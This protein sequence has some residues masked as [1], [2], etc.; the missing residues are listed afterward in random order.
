M[1]LMTLARIAIRLDG[2]EESTAKTSL[3][4]RWSYLTTYRRRLRCTPGE[5]F[6]LQL[7]DISR[8]YVRAELLRR[9]CSA[10]DHSCSKRTV[11]SLNATE[12]S[13]YQQISL[14]MLSGSEESYVLQLKRRVAEELEKA[15]AWMPL[16]IAPQS[17]AQSFTSYRH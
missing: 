13:H 17:R 10:Y 14:F 15:V 2:A 11:P 1:K 4:R 5:E 3:P 16:I 12:N 9:S 7:V 6:R 8:Q